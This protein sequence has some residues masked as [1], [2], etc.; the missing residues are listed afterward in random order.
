MQISAWHSEGAKGPK[1][2]RAHAE[3]LRRFAAQHDRFERVSKGSVA[4]IS[5]LWYILQP[6]GFTDAVG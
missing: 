4:Q 1:N 3:M 5:R 2:L 6:V